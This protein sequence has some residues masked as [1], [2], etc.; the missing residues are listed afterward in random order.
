[1]ER[2]RAAAALGAEARKTGA[3]DIAAFVRKMERLYDLM[4]RVSKS[5]KR[6]GLLREDFSF[7]DS[8]QPSP[9]PGYDSPGAQP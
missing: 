4:A 5:T 1:M 2:P 9:L 6:Q 3:Y 7:L 8:G